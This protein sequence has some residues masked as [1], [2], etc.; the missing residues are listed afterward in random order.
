MFVHSLVPS[1]NHKNSLKEKKNTN[2][3]AQNMSHI[4]K[5]EERSACQS[6]AAEAEMHYQAIFNSLSADNPICQVPDRTRSNGNGGR[7]LQ[8]ANQVPVLV[9]AIFFP[10]LCSSSSPFFPLSSPLR[11]SQG[12]SHAVVT[13]HR[14]PLHVFLIDSARR[15][16]N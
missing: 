8:I 2:P 9:A 12:V 15:E 11:S 4:V 16:S 5:L 7:V 1:G 13:W 6:S 14:V 3:Q 10:T